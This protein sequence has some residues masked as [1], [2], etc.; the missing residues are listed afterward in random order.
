MHIALAAFISEFVLPHRLH[1][2]I[3]HQLNERM[4]DFSCSQYCSF[5]WAV[6]YRCDL[7][8]ISPNNFDAAQAIQD[9]QKLSRGPASHFSSSC[10]WRIRWVQH[11]DVD[12]N[13]D[14][15]ASYSILQRLNDA[16]SANSVE[17]SGL[18]DVEATGLV[19]GEIVLLVRDWRSDSCVDR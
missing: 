1:R 19:V 8:E 16:G 15:R 6:V 18:Q 13:V 4:H 12:T 10:R 7:D 14:F 9:R 5:A 11:V 17:M 3:G 2:L